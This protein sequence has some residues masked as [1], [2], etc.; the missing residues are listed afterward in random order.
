MSA[1]SHFVCIMSRPSREEGTV[2][3][4]ALSYKAV[5]T[6]CCESLYSRT[7][8][9]YTDFLLLINGKQSEGLLLLLHARAVNMSHI[10][11][12]PFNPL[13]YA[14]NSE[15][16]ILDLVVVPIYFPFEDLLNPSDG[17]WTNQ[18]EYY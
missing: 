17:D 18:R 14:S 2:T 16:V 11:S 9:L 4:G 7:I 12:A 8:S 3:E 5:T 10:G 6:F 1:I 13:I 15:I